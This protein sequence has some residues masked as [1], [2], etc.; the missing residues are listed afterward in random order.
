MDSVVIQ[1]HNDTSS[2]QSTSRLTKAREGISH[3]YVVRLI[4]W[5]LILNASVIVLRF[6][7][8][9]QLSWRNIAGHAFLE[10]CGGLISGGVA[11]CLWVQYRVSTKREALLAT[12][13]FS[14]LMVGQLVHA[15]TSA[16]A[17][18]ELVF[19]DRLGHQFYGVWTLAAG[20]LLIA[21]AQSGVKDT[22]ANCRRLGLRMIWGSQAIALL[23]AA[24]AVLIC[25]AQLHSRGMLTAQ[26]MSFFAFLTRT[27]GSE[28]FVHTLGMAAMMAALVVFVRRYVDEED[29]FSDG[30][31]RCLA[32]A[33]TGMSA[34]V[35][36]TG[37]FDILW[38]TSHIFCIFA[39][40]VLLIELG[41]EFGMSYANA[42]SRIEHLEAVHRISSQ[43]GN[44][45]DL[46]VVL[47]VLV[48][49]IADLL[50]A[51]YA[52]VMLVDDTGETLR[53]IST[54]GLP[55]SPLKSTEPQ[56]IEGGGRPG[57]YSGHTARAF[58]EKRVCIVDD[59]FAD[60]EFVPWKLLSQ[61]NGYAV[62]T[63]L[64][65]QDVVLGVMNLF[66]D[67]HIPINDERVRLFETLAQAAAVSI[68]NAQLYDRALEANPMES[69]TANLFRLRL[70]A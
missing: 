34:A 15:T 48:S 8:D 20:I 7:P 19:P 18:G 49:D 58:R 56:R 46:R 24:V 5:M 39:T 27:A 64:V 57:F 37:V 28:I 61:S 9:I 22:K 60:V 35:I 3:P 38:W 30:I 63:P 65:Y 25:Q 40:L 51:R 1:L 54:H 31:I 10:V 59:V 53:T 41:R 43:L 2:I 55:E 42:Q 52:A 44:T 14:G 70:A 6:L 23:I 21:A 29:T 4:V 32:L 50:Q 12:V 36:S 62:S 13:A 33:L 45:L 69:D 26:Q 16:M 47:L 68:A 11:Y 17:F 66:F 67:A